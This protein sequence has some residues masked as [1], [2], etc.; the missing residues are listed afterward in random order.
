MILNMVN[1]LLVYIKYIIIN[2]DFRATVAAAE[3]EHVTLKPFSVD[4][5]KTFMLAAATS[6]P[7]EL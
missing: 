5:L 6:C 1:S 4:V 2:G 7:L 3:G